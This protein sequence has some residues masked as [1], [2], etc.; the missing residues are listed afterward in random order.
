MFRIT[1]NKKLIMFFGRRSKFT[2]TSTFLV[3]IIS[4]FSVYV[5]G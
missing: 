3:S 5:T 4:T 1:I 2:R